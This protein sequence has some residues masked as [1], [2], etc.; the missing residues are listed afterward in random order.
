M[1]EPSRQQI[2][3]AIFLRQNGN[4][5][6][7]Q[8]G[9]ITGKFFGILTQGLPAGTVLNA[10]SITATDTIDGVGVSG[11]VSSLTNKTGGTISGGKSG[12]D[13]NAS[14][15]ATVTNEQGATITGGTNGIITNGTLINAGSI[16][17]TGTTG[18]GVPAIS[19]R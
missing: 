6:N 1:A 8:D 7:L 10:G 11:L 3:T 2:S 14:G 5:T 13:I 4:V 15:G 9:T 17:A 18:I 16:T 19:V 12:V